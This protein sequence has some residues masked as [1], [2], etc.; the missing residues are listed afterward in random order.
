M[1]KKSI[2]ELGLALMT[3]KSKCKICGM[4]ARNWDVH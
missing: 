2:L 4:R 1:L 3:L